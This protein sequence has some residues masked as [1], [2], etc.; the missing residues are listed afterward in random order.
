MNG[1]VYRYLAEDH[2]RLEDAL[3]R[4]TAVP[5]SIDPAAYL[6][7]RGG[8]LRH[9]GM[10][11]KILLPAAQIARGGEALP[12][13]ARLRL[14]HGALAALLVMTPT[15]A[16]VAAIQAILQA[17][18]PVEEGPDG[19]YAQCERLVGFDSDD[20]LGRLQNAAPV[21]MASYSDSETARQSARHA[22]QRAGYD[23][24]F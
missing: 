18:N 8:L 14:D 24:Q 12:F 6:E 9:I 22:L 7:F 23:L 16:I 13:A 4:A 17:H 19:V 11:E 10:E 15:D 3:R 1:K 5:R 21:A 2:R 20:V